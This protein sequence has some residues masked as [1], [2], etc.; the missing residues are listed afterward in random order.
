MMAV[1]TDATPTPELRIAGVTRRF[2]GLVAVADVSLVV[3]G[4]RIHG[5][6][7]P[8]GAGKSTMISLISGFLRPNSGSIVFDGHEL[9][10]L[11]ASAIARL[12]VARTFQR[13]A[14]LLGLSALENVTAGMHLH[15]RSWLGA[16]LLRLPAMRREARDHAEAARALLDRVG[17]ADAAETPAGTLTFG[18]LRF[19]EI[20]RVLAMQPRV[21]MFDEPAAGLNQPESQLLATI[22]RD[23]RHAG[24]GILLVDHDVPFV[25]DLCDEITVM[26]SGKVI[27]TGDPRQI[28][29][30]PRVRA[31]YLGDADEAAL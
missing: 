11:E 12:G 4:G 26:E 7:G 6:I 9:T 2:G 5:L 22:L 8:N 18:E 30:D 23:L 24:V 29:D 31:A 16:V 13:A 17:L 21:I 1:R 25:F 19:L 27:A 15:Y 10:Q 28:Y 3:A 20:A 14:P